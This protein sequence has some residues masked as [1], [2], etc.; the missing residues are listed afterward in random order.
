MITVQ[1]FVQQRGAKVS[2]N[3]LPALLLLRRESP[4]N[5]F[6]RLCFFNF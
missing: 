6:F 4:A 1:E 2:E 5:V 3:I